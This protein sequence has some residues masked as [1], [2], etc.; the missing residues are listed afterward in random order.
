MMPSTCHVTEAVYR[1]HFAD[2]THYEIFGEPPVS[3]HR[4]L[5][6]CGTVCDVEQVSTEPTCPTCVA[7]KQ[8][9]EQA[10]I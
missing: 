3:K 8:Q 10:E 5:A 2:E 9:M 1:E 6:I 7:L 4:R